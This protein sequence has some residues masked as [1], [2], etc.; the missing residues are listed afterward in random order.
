MKKF[1]P[2]LLLFLT[3]TSFANCVYSTSA[4]KI[5]FE[6]EAYKTL[7]KA[8]VKGSFRNLGIEL[9]NQKGSL[10][11]VLDSISFNIDTAS[12]N[13]KNTGRDANIV[14]Y[15]FQK[16]SSGLDITGNL[17]NYSKNSMSAN[18][19]MNGIQ[20]TIELESQLVENTLKST[21]VINLLDFKMDS[22]LESL[23]KACYDL[24]KGKTWS[25]VTVR[26]NIEIAKKC[27]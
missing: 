18:I 8:P 2:F 19:K 24:H 6:W 12:V 20:K 26:L 1:A 5:S 22:S 15:F 4:D 16:M 25:D 23:N 27:D 13:T 14:K 7:E 9:K 17:Q 3:S 10:K 21:G 11:E